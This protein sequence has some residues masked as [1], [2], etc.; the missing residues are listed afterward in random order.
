MPLTHIYENL[1]SLFQAIKAGGTVNFVESMDTLPHNLKEVSPSIFASPPRIW[2]KF[3][4]MIAIRMADSTPSKKFLYKLA[5]GVGLKYVRTPEG[6]SQR[7]WWSLLYWPF[8]GL[9]LYHLKRQLGLERVRVAICGAA[10]ASP[11]LFQF[12]NAIGI[13]LREGYGQTESTGVIALQRL[14]RPR[15]GY[16]GEV[17]PG[18]EVRIAE[19]GEILAKG[20]NVF[21][22]ILKTRN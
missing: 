14:D 12:Y 16:V 19:D 15:W 5:I 10:P 13:P 18:V 17:V 4:S 20:A 7:F 21:K 3:A 2:E 1:I 9:V 8:Y 11:E 6:S 22:G